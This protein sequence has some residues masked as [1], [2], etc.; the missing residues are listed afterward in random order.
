MDACSH[1]G[2]AI[3]P[4]LE[5]FGLG[6]V[7]EQRKG[8][9]SEDQGRKFHYDWRVELMLVRT[10]SRAEQHGKQSLCRRRP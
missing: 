7:G 9:N 5:N 8:K 3:G 1:G 6:F 2:F 10:M 4:E